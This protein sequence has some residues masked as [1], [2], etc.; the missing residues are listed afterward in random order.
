MRAGGELVNQ[1]RENFFA[2]PTFAKKEHGNVKIGDQRGLGA[3]L[4]QRGA[5]GDKEYVIRDL[6]DFAAERLLA[7][8]E[9]E[10]DDRI[11][12]GFLKWLGDGMLRGAVHCL[13]DLSRFGHA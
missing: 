10:V 4:A 5:S 7:L 3:N 6:L 9:A 13:P 2:G 11:Q 1:A 12:F 8:S